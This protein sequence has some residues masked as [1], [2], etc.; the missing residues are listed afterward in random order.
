MPSHDFEVV[1]EERDDA[2]A[3]FRVHVPPDLVFFEGHFEGRPML[4]G[5]AQLVALA[6]RRAREAWPHLGPA[7]RMVRVKFQ[8]V[9]LPGD[10]LVL[11][12]ERATSDV[13]ETVRY[14]LARGEEPAS[15]G[16][17]VFGGQ[18]ATFAR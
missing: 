12:L 18:P 17:I 7:R 8:A 4:P 15:T 3:R 5:V 10:E 16:A 6:E 13:D 2:R 9:I 14:R 11:T 1:L